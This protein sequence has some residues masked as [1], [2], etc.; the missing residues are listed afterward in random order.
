MNTLN[1]ILYSVKSEQEQET[2]SKLSDNRLE[3]EGQKMERG[4]LGG[5]EGG[6]REGERESDRG[7][8]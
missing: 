2:H 5:G 8:W 4:M 3:R 6:H 1:Y 7:I